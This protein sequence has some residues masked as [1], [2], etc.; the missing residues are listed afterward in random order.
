MPGRSVP[1][2][3]RGARLCPQAPGGPRPR[4]PRRSCV[5]VP[6]RLLVV[7]VVSFPPLVGANTGPPDRCLST[8]ARRFPLVRAA[9]QEVRPS[10]PRMQRVPLLLPLLLCC[11]GG[12][13]AGLGETNIIRERGTLFRSSPAS[14]SSASSSSSSPSQQGLWPLRA[15]W[16]RLGSPPLP[17][18]SA[19]FAYKARARH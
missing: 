11:A 12:T 6:R 16:S 1:A 2:P 8:A 13:R 14:S 9:A 18:P 19:L 4:R 10:Q 15:E 5:A 7:V 17:L 3:S